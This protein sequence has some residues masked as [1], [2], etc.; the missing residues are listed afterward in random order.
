MLVAADGHEG[1]WRG[2]TVSEYQGDELA[3]INQLMAYVT[4]GV[5]AS[6]VLHLQ[7]HQLGMHGRHL[8]QGWAWVSMSSAGMQ[9]KPATGW[10][11]MLG[12]LSIHLSA[13]AA[14]E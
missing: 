13:M 9:S 14:N 2:L 8:I 7:I 12:D 6:S 11:G 1:V 5:W 10:V 3:E 4:I